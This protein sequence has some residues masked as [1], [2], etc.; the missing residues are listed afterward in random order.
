[1]EKERKPEGSK[2]F[3]FFCVLPNISRMSFLKADEPDDHGKVTAEIGNVSLQRFVIPQ[4]CVC[5]C[6]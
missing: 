1:M 4:W 2:R 6:D 3:P 5:V